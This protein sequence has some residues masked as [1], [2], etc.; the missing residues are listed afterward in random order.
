MLVAQGAL[1]SGCL[2]YVP[3]PIANAYEEK[4]KVIARPRKGAP[5]S[6]TIPPFE[7]RHP[8]QLY[9]KLEVYLASGD[10]IGVYCAPIKQNPG[11]GVPWVLLSP[12]GAYYVYEELDSTWPGRIVEFQKPGFRLQPIHCKSEASP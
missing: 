11:I 7:I 10:Q 5:E 2:E 12:G 6:L 8:S 4:I 3:A 9:K 1:L